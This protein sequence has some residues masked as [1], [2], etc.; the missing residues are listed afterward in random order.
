MWPHLSKKS[1]MENF[2][3]CAVGVS[4]AICDLVLYLQ[5]ES[6]NISWISPGRISFQYLNTVLTIQFSTLSL[7]GGQFIFLKC[8]GSIR[9]SEVI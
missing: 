2:I 1:L 9:I 6:L 7:A 5:S 8:D 3:F 4:N